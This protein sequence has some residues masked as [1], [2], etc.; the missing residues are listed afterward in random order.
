VNKATDG[1]NTVTADQPHATEIGHVVETPANGLENPTG[2]DPLGGYTIVAAAVGVAVGKATG[3]AL[4]WLR[5][6]F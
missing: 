5:R 4:S 2:V 1:L 6:A 3:T